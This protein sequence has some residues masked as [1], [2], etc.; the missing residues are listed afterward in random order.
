M[1]SATLIVGSVQIL[2]AGVKLTVVSVE[3]AGDIATIVLQGASSA[4]RFSV[5]LSAAAVETAS[6]AGETASLA[7]GASV[8]TVAMSTGVLLVDSAG[9]VIAFIAN[10]LGKAM[11]LHA[12]HTGYRS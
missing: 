10:E 1:G 12:L 6:E 9:N 7:I 2:A 5:Q 11:F 8:A 3:V 4:A